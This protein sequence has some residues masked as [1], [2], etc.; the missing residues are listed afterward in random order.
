MRTIIID[1][2]KQAVKDLNERLARFSEVEVVAAEHS[3]LDGNPSESTR[4]R[5]RR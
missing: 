5:A 1:D 4:N 3:G 2:N